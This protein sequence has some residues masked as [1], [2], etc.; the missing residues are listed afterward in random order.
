MSHST[1]R[2]ADRVARCACAICA[3]ALTVGL[4]T[5]CQPSDGS[6]RIVRQQDSEPK[7]LSAIERGQLRGK[8][9]DAARTGWSAFEANDIEGMRQYFWPEFVDRIAAANDEYE[10]AGRLRTRDHD[11]TFFDV[12]ELSSDGSTAGATMRI[13]DNSY[14]VE[15]DG[16][17]TSA[18]GAERQ[19]T[20][21][22]ERQADGTY[23]I[24]NVIAAGDLLK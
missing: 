1:G 8:A 18:G 16:S 12:T 19:V 10:S 4:V 3:C 11:I 14:F 20:I 9:L 22:L 13:N 15:P 5:G 23:R 21:K 2:P 24:A 7:G 17:R 6:T